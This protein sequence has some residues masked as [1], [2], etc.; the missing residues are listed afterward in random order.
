[1]DNGKSKKAVFWF[2]VEAAV[3]TLSGLALRG[4][5]MVREG[6]VEGM[7]PWQLLKLRRLLF[8]SSAWLAFVG[9]VSPVSYLLRSRFGGSE[10]SS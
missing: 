7:F 1:M 2:T 8:T 6:H 10:D 3:L 4:A 5:L 9:L